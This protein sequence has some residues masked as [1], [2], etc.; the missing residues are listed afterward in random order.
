VR[1]SKDWKGL[2]KKFQWSESS[3]FSSFSS[4]RFLLCCSFQRDQLAKAVC[5]YSPWPF[6][7]WYDRPQAS[8]RTKGGAGDEV[9]LIGNEPELEFLDH[10]PTVRDD[11]QV[12]HGRIGEYVVIARQSGENWFNRRRR[13]YVL[14][15][16]DK[17]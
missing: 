9:P 6:L 7:Y 11:T 10:V 13:G 12:L 1:F 14:K 8:P 17:S 2:R 5:F 3:G 15:R 4:R 16:K